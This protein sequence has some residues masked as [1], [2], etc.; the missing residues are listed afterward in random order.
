M[1]LELCPSGTGYN[2]T[3]KACTPCQLDTYRQRNVNDICEP[4]PDGTFTLKTG[5]TS[6]EDCVTIGIVAL[7]TFFEGGGWET[8]HILARIQHSGAAERPGYG[9]G[10]PLETLRQTRLCY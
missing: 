4:C 6:Q 7:N 3:V 10:K 2:F 9:P 8:G 5:A 1:C